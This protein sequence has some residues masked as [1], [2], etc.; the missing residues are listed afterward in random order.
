MKQARIFMKDN[1]A[2]TL[3]E[4]EN[5]YTFVYDPSYLAN[6]SAEAISL[7]L[8]LYLICHKALVLKLL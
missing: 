2:G 8:P 4:D 7:T 3:T 1:F 6:E 5:G